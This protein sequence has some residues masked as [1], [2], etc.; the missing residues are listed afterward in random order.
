[1]R[2][3][4]SALGATKIDP[5]VL[6]SA[7]RLQ[8]E[9][10]LRREQ[11]NADIMALARQGVSIKRIVRETGHSLRLVRQVVRGQ[12]TDVFRI[13]QSSLEAHLPWLDAPVGQRVP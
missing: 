3:I 8:Y 2:A 12:R 10:Y 1:M 5:D 4:R 7:E 9:G 13:R 6:T 11:T